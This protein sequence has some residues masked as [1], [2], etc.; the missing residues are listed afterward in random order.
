MEP[1]AVVVR[2]L[3]ANVYLLP[4]NRAGPFAE[5]GAIIQVRAGAYADSLV[6]E[7]ALEYWNGQAEETTFVSS[8]APILDEPERSATVAPPPEEELAVSSRRKRR[9]E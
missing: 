9:S 4:N 5:A 3:E 8:P 1:Q 7:G 2:V 6:A